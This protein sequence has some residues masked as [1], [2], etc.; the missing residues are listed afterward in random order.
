[1]SL[2]A[3]CIWVPMH[4]GGVGKNLSLESICQSRAGHILRPPTFVCQASNLSQFVCIY[5]K[6]FQEQ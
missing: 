6:L 1:M 2:A 4:L 3:L 5:S